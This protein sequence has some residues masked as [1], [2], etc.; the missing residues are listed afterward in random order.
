MVV[1]DRRWRRAAASADR[2]VCL[3]CGRQFNVEDGI[4]QLFWPHD[5][6]DETSDVTKQVKAFYEE[7]PFPNYDD[8]DSVRV[9]IEKARR[10]VYAK[11]LNA[12]LPFNSTVLEVGCGTGQLTNFLGVSCRRVIGT[13]M[14]MNSLRLGETFRRQHGLSRVR[15]VQ[16]NLFRP[17]FKAG[18][19]DVILCNG[20]LHHTADPVG[21]FQGLV[22]LLRPGGHI[23]IGL[24]NWYG[25]FFTDLRRQIFRMTGN[26]A[27][28]IDPYL[29]GTPVGESKRK[30]W[31]A[32]QYQHPHESEHTVDEILQWFDRADCSS[33]AGFLH[34]PRAAGARARHASTRWRP[35]RGSITCSSS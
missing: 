1:P 27:K 22:P 30:A 18:V 9:L 20:V 5:R 15:F 31:F 17:C 2:L 14:C 21:G 10:G 11:E 23:V 19:F 32:D 28:W 3:A 25:R 35:D 33:F 12:A 6:F 24:Y 16:M 4:P 13:D 34:R 7:T 26:R 8:H 29:R